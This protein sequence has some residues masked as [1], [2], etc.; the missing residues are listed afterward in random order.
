M[1]TSAVH[2]RY[3]RAWVL[4]MLSSLTSKFRGGASEPERAA[5]PALAQGGACVLGVPGR[6]GPR[7]R[8][9]FRGRRGYRNLKLPSRTPPSAATG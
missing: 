4:V 9:V 3:T 7:K 5:L 6:L 8:C 2:R 1:M